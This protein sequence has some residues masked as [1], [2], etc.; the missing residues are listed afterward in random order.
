MHPLSSEALPQH[1]RNSECFKKEQLGSILEVGMNYIQELE[2]LR[3][4]SKVL[5]FSES[6]LWSY[7]GWCRLTRVQDI[8]VFY[9][10][11]ETYGDY[12]E[13]A[14]LVLKVL[15]HTV[16]EPYFNEETKL[17]L[18]QKLTE[19]I[20]FLLKR[21]V[22][23]HELLVLLYKISQ[24]RTLQYLEDRLDLR[25]WLELVHNHTTFCL[26]SQVNG[27]TLH[28]LVGF[29][30][31]LIDFVD[32]KQEFWYS[33]ITEVTKALIKYSVEH[34][35][36]GQ[37]SKVSSLARVCFVEVGNLLI[38]EFK[39]GAEKVVSGEW[40]AQKLGV[41]VKVLGT[42]LVNNSEQYH[43]V[44]QKLTLV[45]T[46]THQLEVRVQIVRLTLELLERAQNYPVLRDP[47]LVKSCFKVLGVFLGG[48]LPPKAP[49]DSVLEGLGP[50]VLKKLLRVCL[51][52]FTF[53]PGFFNKLTKML[54]KTSSGVMCGKLE[55]LDSHE[56]LTNCENPN[57]D[58]QSRLE[59]MEGI[60]RIYYKTETC[61]NLSQLIS[62]G[63]LLLAVYDLR[64]F[65]RG[66]ETTKDFRVFMNWY[67]S[68]VSEHLTSYL[69]SN[70]E[71][72]GIALITLVRDLS[73]NKL[74][75]L[76]LG[77]YSSELITLFNY[78]LE[79]VSF[80]IS[81]LMQTNNFKVFARTVEVFSNL[82]TGRHFGVTGKIV[83]CNQDIRN[84]F[85]AVF[86][87]VLQVPTQV[88]LSNQKTLKPVFSFIRHISNHK[89]LLPYF[90]RIDPLAMNHLLEI[91]N[92]TVD[93][94][95][96]DIC[97][98][99]F[100][101]L[102]EVIKDLNFPEKLKLEFLETQDSGL[103]QLMKTLFLVLL[104]GNGKYVRE[105]SVPLLG[106]VNLK[107]SYYLE[108]AEWVTTLQGPTR[109]Q[110]L[111]FELE[112][113]WKDFL[114]CE[115]PFESQKNMGK[116]KAFTEALVNFSKKVVN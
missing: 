3:L 38:Q 107:Q 29:W 13:G 56:I 94:L 5:D 36:K 82:L 54:R 102:S 44:T 76:E 92:H 96:H 70:F 115:D 58:K 74:G 89:V 95:H 88:V 114:W 79:L 110:L 47:A 62:C 42:L 77:Q 116:A 97:I 105:L 90:Y 30:E 71:S 63:D 18:L 52:P 49:S 4:V 86:Q 72:L 100:S 35:S 9:Q 68:A 22:I 23:S 12:S 46:Q 8:A 7:Q 57:L 2:A 51:N 67:F 61:L 6:G 28:Y 14:E 32:P 60:A 98:L 111:E 45:E 43:Q 55:L 75:R 73:E 103:K 11:Y 19:F 41:L 34:E 25:E 108:I 66:A 16:T 37:V 93:S 64:G 83:V 80:Y 112:Q 84:N 109:Q 26:S 50:L 20:G 69:S 99:S 31:C 53:C 91:L 21:E 10:V 15:G 59:Y 106:L 17:D 87:L 33:K 78:C 85:E 48:Y 81:Q 104:K 65:L 27:N 24:T 40:G 1:K 39:S 101:T 113:L